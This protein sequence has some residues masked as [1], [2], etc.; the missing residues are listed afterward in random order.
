MIAIVHPIRG[1]EFPAEQ[2]ADYIQRITG[3]RPVLTAKPVEARGRGM[4]FVIGA[5]AANDLARAIDESEG[6]RLSAA[7]RRE[8]CYVVWPCRYA[9]RAHLVCAGGDAV[10]TAYAVFAY[11]E[12][13]CKAGF[14]HD[15]DHVP[16][17]RLAIPREPFMSAPRL[18][19]RKGPLAAGSGHYGIPKFHVRYWTVD[20]LK[21][22]IRWMVKHGLN[23]M[24]QHMSMYH[25]GITRGLAREVCA[26]LGY[27]IGPVVEEEEY[28]SGFPSTWDWPPEYLVALTKEVFAYARSLGI[29]VDLQPPAGGGAPGVQAALS[30]VRVREE[31]G[32][33][34][35]CPDPSL[36]SLL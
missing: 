15:G 18:Q 11:L 20:E 2:L 8:G 28:I 10:T 34:G 32:T 25:S 16:R 4:V 23:L 12:R 17:R 35:V 5:P 1:Y 9:G 13:S 30:A 31:G 3:K 19:H 26:D 29:R 33:L 7:L 27:P 22:E 6:G 24:S 36:G 21:N 14:F